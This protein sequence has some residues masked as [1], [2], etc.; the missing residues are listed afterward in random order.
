[1][2]GCTQEAKI[3]AYKALIRP[4]L[5]YACAVWAPF[6][7]CDI[8]LLESVQNRAICW[9]KSFWNP[10]VQRWSKSSA[11]CIKDLK[12]PSFKV[13]HDYFPSGLFILK[14]LQLIFPISINCPQG[15]TL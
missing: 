11:D 4:H 7:A 14:Q 12:W 2:Y 15:H 9:I 10:I 5:E 6:T 1:M 8:A 13:C 3:N